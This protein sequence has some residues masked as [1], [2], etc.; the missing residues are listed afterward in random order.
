MTSRWVFVRRGAFPGQ[1]F[2]I[3]Q[4]F[5]CHCSK[6]RKAFG[7]ASSA[8]ALAAEDAFSWVLGSDGIREY[9][10][11]S[12]FQTALLSRLRLDPAAVLC[13]SIK[14][15]GCLWDCWTQTRGFA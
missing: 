9:Q 4:V 11:E 2:Q 1:R 5:K 6:C 8:A 12:G 10:C 7:G 13:R 15:T 14:C 3:G